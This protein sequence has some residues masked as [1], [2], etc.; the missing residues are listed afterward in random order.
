MRCVG[1]YVGEFELGG[2]WSAGVATVCALAIAFT[3]AQTVAI[4][5]RVEGAVEGWFHEGDGFLLRSA[6]CGPRGRAAAA[7]VAVAACGALVEIS[8]VSV[9]LTENDP[10]ALESSVS[11]LFSSQIFYAAATAAAAALSGARPT[12]PA[13]LDLVVAF[14]AA[15][16]GAVCLAVAASSPGDALLP[17]AVAGAAVA[18]ATPLAVRLYA[19]LGEERDRPGHARFHDARERRAIQ[20]ARAI[21]SSQAGSPA[22]RAAIA[23]YA[24][25]VPVLSGQAAAAGVLARAGVSRARSSP[26]APPRQQQQRGWPAHRGASVIEVLDRHIEDELRAARAGARREASSA[27][28]ILGP[29]SHA[30][31]L[32]DALLG[33]LPGPAAVAVGLVLLWV[34][35]VLQTDAVQ[36]AS[37]ALG[38]RRRRVSAFVLGPLFATPHIAVT[39]RSL[40]EGRVEAV[41]LAAATSAIANGA[42]LASACVGAWASRAALGR[43]GWEPASVEEGRSALSL[44]A[45]CVPAAAAAAALAAGYRGRRRVAP[46]LAAAAVGGYVA[47][48]LIA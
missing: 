3:F 27:A 18:A 2:S 24:D 5:R 46:L 48:A 38:L 45:A 29:A 31:L 44:A 11:I 37:C 32:P 43:G 33:A 35:S 15:S 4:W 8:T 42:G 1:D 7:L 26:A 30:A 22:R 9:E 16:L 21:V 39:W 40:R 13:P 17:L 19:A 20:S 12:E 10:E 47:T 34:V 28:E 14:W 41:A 25:A 23:A 6:W 36:I